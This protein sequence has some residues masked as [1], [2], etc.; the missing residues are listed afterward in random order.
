MTK[1]QHTPAENGRHVAEAI[2]TADQLARNV[3]DTEREWLDAGL[4]NWT[5]EM[6]RYFDDLTK[7]MHHT[8]KD[9]RACQ[10]PLDVLKVEQEWCAARSKAYL[11]AGLR[12]AQ[13]FT[14]ATARLGAPRP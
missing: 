8:F 4:D 6:S 12:F 13:T 3:A 10:T 14:E 11:E 7:Q 5:A 9:L 2:R 1:A